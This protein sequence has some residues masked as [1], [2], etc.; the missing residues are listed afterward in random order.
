MK[1]FL[2]VLFVVLM[3]TGFCQLVTF[4]QENVDTCVMVSEEKGVATTTWQKVG[5]T[6]IYDPITLNATEDD[7]EVETVSDGLEQI[8]YKIWSSA[9][10]LILMIIAFVVLCVTKKGN[11]RNYIVVFIVGALLITFIWATTFQSKDDYYSTSVG[12]ENSVGTVTLTIRCDTVLGEENSEHIPNDGCVL[13]VT[14]FEIEQGDTVY[15]VLLDATKE[16]NIQMEVE[17]E[18]TGAYVTGINY[19]YG[20]DF[21]DLS[22]WFYFVN[23]DSAT[24][25]CGACEVKPDDEIE[26]LYTCNMG[27][28]L[29]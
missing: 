15:D 29:Q 17:G 9:G 12:K 5:A 24:V 19:L 8:D 20:G 14:E 18:G 21:G 6:N 10:I 11:K 4:A 1:K 26:F 13:D 22:G 2:S 23:G 7:N 28:D 27:E 25:G 3:L 16:Y